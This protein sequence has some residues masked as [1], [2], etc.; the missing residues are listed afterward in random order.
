MVKPNFS[1]DNSDYTENEELDLKDLF[2]F[3]VRNR[4]LIGTFSIVF[5]IISIIYSLFKKNIWEGRF[6][7]VLAPQNVNEMPFDLLNNVKIPGFSG[8][9][10]SNTSSLATEVAILE[11][12]FVLMS[13]FNF[14]KDEILC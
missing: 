6:Q 10:M 7:I 2:E 3:F 1:K 9:N 13:A 5:F 4:L 11:S 12:P 14:V 8:I